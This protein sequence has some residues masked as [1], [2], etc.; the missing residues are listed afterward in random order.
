[1]LVR[2]KLWIVS[3][4]PG[5]GGLRL[6]SFW[7]CLY[8]CNDA[9]SL[10]LWNAKWLILNRAETEITSDNKRDLYTGML[11]QFFNETLTW[12]F[13]THLKLSEIHPTLRTT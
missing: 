5:K 7:E 2:I 9:Q 4:L 6:L 8:I 3:I 12:G 10:P 1:M 13:F 11:N